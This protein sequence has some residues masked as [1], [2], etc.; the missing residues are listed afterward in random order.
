[1]KIEVI[2]EHSVAVDLLTGGWCFDLGCRGFQFSEAMRD[3]GCFVWAFDLE[4]MQQPKGISF[5]NQA[6]SN[7]TGFAKYKNTKDPQAKHLCDDGDMKVYCSDINSL[8]D[9][10]G[11]AVCD[12]LKL[13]I[14]GEEYRILSDEK[15]MPRPRQISIEFHMHAHRALHDQYYDKCMENLLRYYVPV[16]HE[17]TQAHGAGLNYWDSLFVRRDIL[18]Q[19]WPSVDTSTSPEMIK[20]YKAQNGLL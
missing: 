6:V 7:F 4:P 2:H 19:S 5:F 18:E 14:E 12:V 13:D 1:M 15:F 10:M 11:S 17:L 20:F 3:L 16:K 8:Y 9:K